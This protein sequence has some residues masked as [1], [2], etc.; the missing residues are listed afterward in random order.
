MAGIVTYKH[1]HSFYSTLQFILKIPG[2][3]VF[4]LPAVLRFIIMKNMAGKFLYQLLSAATFFANLIFAIVI[5]AVCHFC[6]A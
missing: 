3:P 1:I 5:F 4:F 6:L 2:F